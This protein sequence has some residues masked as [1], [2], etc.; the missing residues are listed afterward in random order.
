MATG[1]AA[2]R[3]STIFGSFAVT[4]ILGCATP[5]VEYKSVEVQIPVPVPCA[6]PL[7]DVPKWARTG[8]T[9]DS[10]IDELAKAA[11]AE[12]MQREAYERELMAAVKGC[13]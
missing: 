3:I 5:P 2:M 8:T 12:L 9:K 4:Q 13:Q 6:A 10:N 7:P 11:I 1:E